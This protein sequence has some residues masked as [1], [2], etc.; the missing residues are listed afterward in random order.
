LPLSYLRRDLTLE[1]QIFA[2]SE[3]VSSEFFVMIVDPLPTSVASAGTL[4]C[5]VPEK[6]PPFESA[7]VLDIG[8][9][10]LRMAVRAEEGHPSPLQEWV[11]LWENKQNSR[12]F[13]LQIVQ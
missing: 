12:Q 3:F 2:S 4:G 10:G 8:G 13:R 11:D 7:A 5:R 1:K 9:E 6:P